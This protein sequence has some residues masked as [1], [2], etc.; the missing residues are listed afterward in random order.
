MI[1]VCHN[2]NN[3]SILDDGVVSEKPYNINVIKGQN[4]IEDILETMAV[5][6]VKYKSFTVM[7]Y[8]TK[9]LN[10]YILICEKSN[11]K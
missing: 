5:S 6:F 3:V 1:W 2:M 8:P 10:E 4:F 11:L 7:P 9:Y